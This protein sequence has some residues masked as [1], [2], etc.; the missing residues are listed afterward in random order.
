LYL[1]WDKCLLPA[2]VEPAKVAEI[3]KNLSSTKA[4]AVYTGMAQKMGV[5]CVA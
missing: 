3:Q 1:D 4:I 5:T 2:W